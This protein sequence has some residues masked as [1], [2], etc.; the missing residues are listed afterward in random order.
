[1]RF[2][3]LLS[4][5][6]TAHGQL[7]PGIDPGLP[8]VPPIESL[9]SVQAQGGGAASGPRL[10][11]RLLR[12]ELLAPAS[13]VPAPGAPG[14]GIDP[15]LRVPSPRT[16]ASRLEAWLG[17]PL[18]GS[19]LVALVDEI[20]V[21]YDTEGYP[22]VL[23]DVPEQDLSEGRL[24][25]RI[26]V[27]RIG[28]VGVGRPRYGQVDAIQQGLRLRSGDLLRR[29]ELDEQMDWYGR[30]L[31]RRPRLFVSPGELPATA[32]LLIGLEERRPWR[33]TSAY[34]NSGPDVL[35]RDRFL[36]GAAGMLPNEQVIA[37]QGVFGLPVSSLEAHAVNWEIPF[38]RVHQSLSIS[39]AYAD[40]ASLGYQPGPPPGVAQNE[41]TSWSLSMLQQFH[42][43]S[44]A[45]WR[46]RVHA[47]VEI[48]S[49]DQFLLFGVARVAPGEVRLVHGRAGYRLDREWEDGAA[50]FG[51]DLVGS[52]GGLMAG[53]D[54]ADFRDYDP[55]AG[56]S[57]WIGRAR[58]SGWWAV[59]KDWRLAWRGSAQI[60][61]S[62]LL[63]VEQFAVGGYQ[64]VRGVAERE[65]FA[66][67]GWVG[68]FE[69]YSPSLRPVEGAR[70]RML[71]FL[72][73]GWLR[74]RGLD[75]N[76]VTGAGLGLRL[77]VSDWVDLRADHGWRLDAGGSRSHVGVSMTF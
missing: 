9:P 12:L 62:S 35:G 51:V 16:L 61:D 3:L 10:M 23:V 21:H 77:R 7:L 57:Y 36:L 15:D 55:R 44:L 28:K 56:A 39:A 71:G 25:L 67:N 11:E 4:A 26:E 17:A 31:F 6:S 46:Q 58:G 38:H 47:G 42:L 49:T 72:D 32:D 65:Y 54:D 1:M 48:K 33:V 8:E 60:S 66:D 75:S 13:A 63:P 19:R 5:V 24:F 69:V 73:H 53:N 34:E 18:E 64:T 40:V 74:S 59:G 41:G 2:L 52:P 50:S 27:G 14:V 45:G 29:A 70:L 68:S 76:S 43:P 22:V 20:L 37:W 30:N